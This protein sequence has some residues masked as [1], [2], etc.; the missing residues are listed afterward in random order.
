MIVVD[1]SVAVQ[2][3][4]D[5]DTS[6]LS[7]TLLSRNDLIAP[8]LLL[9]EVANALYR[10]VFVGDIS[11]QHAALGLAFVRDKVDL[12]GATV[13]R[14]SRAI[15]FANEMNHPVYDCLY[16]VIAEEMDARV[17]TYDQELIS[18]ARYPGKGALIAE[19]PLP[20]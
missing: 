19:L 8:D 11:E 10:K 1:A 12:L 15:A 14:L 5:E 6:E 2:W 17:A 20:P 18:R 9:V 13:D 4:A 7:E 16:L 3:V